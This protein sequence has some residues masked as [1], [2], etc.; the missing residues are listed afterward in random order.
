M[1]FGHEREEQA[2]EDVVEE[3]VVE[4]LDGHEVLVGDGHHDFHQVLF[5]EPAKKEGRKV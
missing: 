3:F 2:H 5:H 1:L 4:G